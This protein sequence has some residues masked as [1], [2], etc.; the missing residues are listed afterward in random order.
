MNTDCFEEMK[1]LRSDYPK[2]IIIGYININSVRNKF[3][4]FSHMMKGMLDIIVIAETKLDS[5]FP[6]NQ[7][8]ISGF[9]SPI[10][11]DISSNSGGI[12]V[13]IKE[14][15]LFKKIE[16]RDIPRDIQIIPI[17]I[18]IRKQ[19]WLLLPIYRN[20]RQ[21]PKYFADNLSRII[22]KH[23]PSRDNV[24][25]IGD[26]NMVIG[27]KVMSTLIST[28]Q[29]FSLYKGETCFKTSRGRSIDLMLTNRKHSF[30]KSQSFET[31]F[32]DHHHVIYTILK[33]TYVKL[34][35]KIIRYRE[36]KNFH[37]EEFQRDLHTKLSETIYT[38]YQVLHS[39]IKSVVQEHAPLKQRIVRGNEKPHVKAEM[40]RAIMKRTRLK[41]RANKTGKKKIS[42]NINNKEI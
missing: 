39:T 20:P 34:S 10:R 23:T 17:E 30:M 1:K 18:N 11:L 24:L 40:R 2:N 21:D 31:G 22:D 6:S 36:Y 12:L 16:D 3:E 5:S 27:D 7:F 38:D 28:Y 29:L 9:K 13:Y 8:T 42:R 26:F 41:K 15:I 33:S 37:K 4:Q 25:I 32:S 19:K 35:P 14:D